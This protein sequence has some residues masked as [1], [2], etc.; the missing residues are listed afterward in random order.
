MLRDNYFGELTP[1]QRKVLDIAYEHNERQL[2]LVEDLLKVAKIDS[3]Y[4]TLDRH[5]VDIV[6][7][8]RSIADGYRERFA[9]KAQE[10]IFE[11]ALPSFFHAV[12]SEQLQLAIESLLD[13]AHAYTPPS[14][15][16]WLAVSAENGLPVIA[17]KDEGVGISSKDM[18]KL[19]QKFR[20]IQNPLSETFG[21]SGLGLYW[22][23]RIVSLHGG[24]ISAQSTEGKG[25][26]FTMYL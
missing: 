26:V 19:F 8:A 20:R 10:L 13:N 7:F 16:I 4:F 1:A 12:D 15:K 23:E 3:G 17:I 18:P 25:S 11:T 21:G 5:T 14:K 2:K 9:L 22:A 6:S 24:R